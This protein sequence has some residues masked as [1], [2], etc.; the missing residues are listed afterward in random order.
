MYT[1]RALL[2]PD[3]LNLIFQEIKHDKPALASCALTCRSFAPMALDLLWKVLET[4]TPV[5]KLL[6]KL[7]TVDGTY[8]SW[9]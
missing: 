7:W 9:P 3:I 2:V 6:P 4:S 8:V 5:K 1:P